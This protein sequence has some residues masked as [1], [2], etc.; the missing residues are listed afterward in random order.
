MG[1]QVKETEA[2]QAVADPAAGGAWN[3]AEVGTLRRGA[4]G[5]LAPGRPRAERREVGARD[6]TRPG[7]VV[8]AETHLGDLGGIA[9]AGHERDGSA[10]GH[11]RGVLR[12]LAPP[13]RARPADVLAD[14]GG[15]QRAG[16]PVEALVGE[17]A[18]ER[19]RGDGRATQDLARGRHRRV[20]QDHGE[21]V[22]LGRVCLGAGRS[23]P[24]R[25]GG[26]VASE[27]LVGPHRVLLH[28]GVH[29]QERRLDLREMPQH[30]RV[31]PVAAGQADGHHAAQ[32]GRGPGGTAGEDEL[33]AEERPDDGAWVAGGLGLG[34]R[35][36]RRAPP[37]RRAAASPRA[38]RTRARSRPANRPRRQP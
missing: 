3:L 13:G 4:Q 26:A 32:R 10:V 23:L 25:K 16:P 14:L 35:L 11:V 27:I 36:V 30:G 38:A 8:G 24:W 15:C 34:R 12:G 2:S 18:H 33:A 7:R 17:G 37:L 5:Q 19:L 28:L 6:R 20:P 9:H 31:L 21:E 22:P 1:S 29:V